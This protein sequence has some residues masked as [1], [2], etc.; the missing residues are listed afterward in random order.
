MHLNEVTIPFNGGA[1]YRLL[2][3]L[4]RD[5]E[6]VAVGQDLYEIEFNGVEALVESFDT[7]HI[8]IKKLD[9]GPVEVGE[10]IAEVL[11]DSEQ[12]GYHPFCVRLSSEQ[13]SFVDSQRGDLARDSWLSMFISESI[14]AEIQKRRT[15]GS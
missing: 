3:W 4:V 8:K 15:S 5:G 7:G 14:A 10:V 11:L 13:V 9:V 2:R 6:H 1:N 12:E